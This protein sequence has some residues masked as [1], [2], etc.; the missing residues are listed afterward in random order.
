MHLN[1]Q[2]ILEAN[3]IYALWEFPLFYFCLDP[4]TKFSMADTHANTILYVLYGIGSF[5][6]EWTPKEIIRIRQLS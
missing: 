5:V 4:R 6:R 3:F 1:M 2:H